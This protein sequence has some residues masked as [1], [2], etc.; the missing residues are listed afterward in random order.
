MITKHHFDSVVA[1]LKREGPEQ[2][3]LAKKER[4]QK[5][6]ISDEVRATVKD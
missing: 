5:K 6:Q 2:L 3:L 1:T 4:V